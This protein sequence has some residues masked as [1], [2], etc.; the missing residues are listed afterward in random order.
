MER[1]ARSP[2]RDEGAALLIILMIIVTITS[3]AL[4]AAT[5]AWS[6]TWRRDNEE[7]LI[8]RGN[9]YVDAILAYRKEHQGQ[10]P[11]NLDDLFK[12]GPRRLRYIR[13]LYR[14]LETGRMN[15]SVAGESWGEFERQDARIRK[16]KE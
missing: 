16:G 5:Q 11:S 2:R 13:K 1:G 12:P 6:V 8:F 10:F 7:E 14:D 15:D 9:Q 4:A 3:I